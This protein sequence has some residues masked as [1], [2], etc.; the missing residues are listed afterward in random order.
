M[1]PRVSGRPLGSKAL[2]LLLL[3]ARPRIASRPRR[4]RRTT[5]AAATAILIFKLSGV[6]LRPAVT[7]V[8]RLQLHWDA[9]DVA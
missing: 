4:R 5:A 3:W 2:L 8:R 6:L 9:F 1:H 7:L